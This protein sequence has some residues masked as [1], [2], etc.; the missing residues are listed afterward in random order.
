MKVIPETRR[1]HHILYLPFYYYPW[2]DISADGLLFPEGIIC[3]VAIV[4]AWALT[5][6]IRYI[7]I[8]IYGS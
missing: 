6:I 1:V 5:G 2:V 4:C 7:F 3:P 8:E